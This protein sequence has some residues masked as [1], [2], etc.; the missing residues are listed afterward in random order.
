M[1]ALNTPIVFNNST[2]NDAT[3][4]GS[5]ST[6]AFI[7]TLSLQI[8]AGSA[9]TYGTAN[10]AINVGD[11]VYVPSQTS[12]RKFNVIASINTS[13]SPTVYT[14]DEVWDAS[15][16]SA[17]CYSGGK[18]AGSDLSTDAILTEAPDGSTIEIEYTGTDYANAG[19]IYTSL[20]SDTSPVTIKGTGSQA[21]RIVGTT[22]NGNCVRL[23]DGAYIWENLQFIQNKQNGGGISCF[24]IFA[25][26]TRNRF[27]KCTFRSEQA[28]L[29]GSLFAD[30]RNTTHIGIFDRCVFDG[31]NLAT[32]GFY[33]TGGTSA[34]AAQILINCTFKDISGTAIFLGDTRTTL[35]KNCIIHDCSE[36]VGFQAD[37]FYMQNVNDCIFYNLS[38]NGITLN[39]SQ[40]V[41]CSNFTGNIFHSITGNA[42]G[43]AA[44]YSSGQEMSVIENNAFYNIAGSNYSNLTA[45]ANDITLT[46]DPFVDAA[47]GDFNVNADAG[48]GDTLRAN[49]YALNTDTSVYPFRQYVS[50]PFGGGGG[51]GSTFHPLAQ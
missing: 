19:T 34:Y 31:N 1:T 26:V 11:L 45:G 21:P 28:Q 39:N 2:G 12:G 24:N 6:R 36:G 47:N 46:A 27:Y 30:G 37:S 38:G 4:S 33:R 16:F 42:F 41:L 13:V 32:S 44:D 22:L 17:T 15:D 25:N 35:V 29:G 51:G 50:D 3:A 10:G 43:A 20:G 5:P 8:T 18:R 23:L 40:N 14:F 48:G 7:T 49:N 9:T